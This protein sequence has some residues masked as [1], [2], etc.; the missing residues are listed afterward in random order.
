MPT[1]YLP[2]LIY[3]IGQSNAIIT[4][5]I[6]HTANITAEKIKAGQD[7]TFGEMTDEDV[8]NWLKAYKEVDGVKAMMKLG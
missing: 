6:L 2:Q 1:G 7:T 3:R 5:C 8:E 4:W